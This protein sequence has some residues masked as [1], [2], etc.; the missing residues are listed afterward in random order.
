MLRSVNDLKGLN[1]R[2]TDG[3]IGSVDQFYFDDETW[4]IRYLVVNAGN[5]L[6]GRMVLISPISLGTVD[7]AAKQLEVTL[8]RKQI[9]NSP[10]IDTHKPVSR[11]HEAE[12]LG[13]YGY[14]FY[15]SGAHLWEPVLHPADLSERT[16]TVEARSKPKQE[17]IDRHLRSTNEVSGYY[18]QAVDGEIGHVEDFLVDEE[19]W[20]IRY[21]V[22]DT[23]NWWAGKKVLV[24]PQWIDSISWKESKVHVDLS[25]ETIKDGPEYDDSAPVTRQY[26]ELLFGNH[27]RGGY[28]L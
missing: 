12:F 2:A 14:P 13:Y 8:T 11:Q 1:L 28:W 24:S 10:N 21:M 7:W 19:T 17:S 3:E 22:V 9:E 25:R 5:W 26:E 20:S 6:V 23:R 16:T 15:W 27:D 4:T 18:I